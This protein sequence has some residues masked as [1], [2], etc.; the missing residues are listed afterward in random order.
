MVPPTSV[1]IPRARTYFGFRPP[2][3]GF[4]YEALTLSGGFSH[5]LR[6][7]FHVL[8]SVLNP[9]RISTSG[10]ASSVFARRY[11]RNLG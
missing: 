1:R 7:P 10:L 11:S 3:P 4:D 2:L 6:L 8:A 9:G 5:T